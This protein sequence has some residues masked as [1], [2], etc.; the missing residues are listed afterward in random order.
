MLDLFK[1]ITELKSL[2][3]LNNYKQKT[4]EQFLGISRDDM[5]DGGQL[6]NVYKDYVKTKDSEAESLLLLHNYEDVKG[7]P[8]LLDMM[9][10]HMLCEG[11]FHAVSLNTDIS[12]QLDGSPVKELYITLE[13]EITVPKDAA[14]RDDAVHIHIFP[15]KTVIRVKLCEGELNYYIPGNKKDGCISTKY[16]IF[17]PQ[18]EI[19][20]EPAYRKKR[21]DR[22]SYFALSETFARDTSLQEKYAAHLMRTL[23]FS[24]RRRTSRAQSQSPCN[25]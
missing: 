2:I 13:N 14:I 12:E 20:C 16:A 5:Y 8:M 21:A 3:P 6:I 23:I 25:P 15:D 11:L 9:L 18:Y 7:M 10:Y 4:I 19:I 24:Q 17:L 22:L 1:K